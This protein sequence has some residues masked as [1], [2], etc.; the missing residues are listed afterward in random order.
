MTPA[1]VRI[2]LTDLQQA[3]HLGG[4]ADGFALGGAAQGYLEIELPEPDWAVL[5]TA[6]NKV[7]ARHP[8][9]RATIVSDAYFE[10]AADVPPYRIQVSQAAADTAKESLRAAAVAAAAPFDRRSWP[11]IRVLGT[12][13]PD[14]TVRL[15]LAYDFTIMDWWSLEVFLGDW[16]AAYAD[17]A[18]P[19]PAADF[20]FAGFAGYLRDDRRLARAREFWAGKI[21]RLSPAPSFTREPLPDAARS[22]Q[23][24]ELLSAAE[25]DSLRAHASARNSTPTALVLTAYADALRLW[26]AE[27][28]FLLN[29]T[30]FDRPPVD[31]IDEAVGDF[32]S[33][34]LID[35]DSPAQAF[36]ER[37]ADVQV[38]LW[39][40]IEHRAMSGVAVGREL[41]R[42]RRSLD[43][44]APVVFTS[45]LGI[46]ANGPRL[47]VVVGSDSR[48]PQALCDL[49]LGEHDGAFMLTMYAQ[50]DEIF[51]PIADGLW[52][53][54]LAWLRNIAASL[55]GAVGP[56]FPAVSGRAVIGIPAEPA[57]RQVTSLN[58]I[59][60]ALAGDDATPALLDLNGATMTYGQLRQR[61]AA[62]AADLAR[63]GAG[64]GALVV[65][66]LDR[67]LDQYV[68]AVAVARTGAGYLPVDTALPPARQRRLIQLARPDLVIT[69]ASARWLAEVADVPH[70][71]SD[72]LLAQ[73]G[74]DL[75]APGRG[76][77]AWLP[78]ADP[79]DLAYVIYTSGSTGEPKGVAVS[80]AAVA[81]TL[82]DVLD[83]FGIGPA[84][85]VLA[86]SGLHFDLSVFDLF[87]L[88]AVGGSA[89]VTAAGTE[90]APEILAE[91]LHRLRPT[92][93]NSVPA[94]FDMVLQHLEDTGGQ[95]PGSLRLV[96]L[97]GDVVPPGLA[98]RVRS[99]AAA[100]P[101]LIAL[102][103]ATEAGIW[104]NYTEMRLA[105][106]VTRIPYG[107]PLRGQWLSIV[108][109]LRRPRPAG[110]I[111][112]IAIMGDSLAQGYLNDPVSTAAKFYRDPITGQ[113][114]YATGDMGF[115]TADGTIEILG[116]LDQQ[117][118]IGGYRIE[119]GEIEAAIRRV[120]GVRGAVVCSSA[121]GPRPVL[122]AFVAADATVTSAVIA[123][124]IRKEL[125]GYMVPKAWRLMPNL[126]LTGNGKVD[127]AALEELAAV[128]P[129][130]FAA[131]APSGEW[132]ATE[133]WLAAAWQDILGRATVTCESNFFE[134]GGDSLLATRLSGRLRERG[135]VIPIRLLFTASTLAEMAAL[136]DERDAEDEF[137]HLSTEQLASM[138]E[139]LGL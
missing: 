83:R 59:A 55:P 70:L 86:T 42:R 65:I 106:P 2:P 78:T 88:L 36:A 51:G 100:P 35:I 93:W 63:S 31:G 54:M 39:D 132:T 10:I 119:L 107:R 69:A 41:R 34:L 11:L 121:S 13:L 114:T 68:W 3:Y 102:G 92:I 40:A 111:G 97:S 9:L 138:V 124:A 126:P 4:D 22:A 87:G 1:P 16:A 137:G 38:K 47:G 50:D 56:G 127:R 135:V 73:G 76:E 24:S 17:P 98:G 58:E 32:T 82:N 67:S 75:S 116:R 131:A 49:V 57:P 134:L 79:G 60:V 91:A 25:S 62:L 74:G 33:T 99:H 71:D 117:V 53:D 26:V 96:M 94:L 130:Q 61:S 64:P 109:G 108:D 12:A 14:G 45:L 48:T 37:L 84:D 112:E 110:C 81:N 136:V 6:L 18:A 103:G 15:H 5:E 52:A 77:L 80:G 30:V 129:Q 123:D 89:V 118:K 125:P 19:V 105:G 44:A 7:I 66:A 115:A 8:M 21:P 101:R 46:K 104:S 72:E 28:S 120:L 23:R 90:R 133:R 43:P 113:R 29:I 122:Q 85:S 128:P 20:D 95:L 139:E 27:P